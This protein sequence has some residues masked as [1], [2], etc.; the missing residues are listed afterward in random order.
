MLICLHI[1]YGLHMAMAGLSSCH[2]DYMAY[3]A[4]NI[5]RRTLFYCASLYCISQIW[6]FLQMEGLGQCCVEQVYR[7]HSSSNIYSLCVSH[8]GNLQYF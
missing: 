4:E 1:D 3:K 8:F 7:C 6:C 2:R 5:Y